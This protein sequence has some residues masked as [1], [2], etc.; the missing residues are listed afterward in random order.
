VIETRVF[1]HTAITALF[2]GDDRAFGFWQAADNDE[3]TLILPAVAVAEANTV[4]GGD[5]NTWRAILGPGRVVVT[6]LDESTAIDVGT[7]VGS[8]VVRQVVRE[9]SQTQG[10]IVT[11]AAWQYPEGAPP[12]WTL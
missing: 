11:A 1:D 10:Q 7:A 6:P 12:I 3:L 8:L 2:R 4:I 5:S 9:A